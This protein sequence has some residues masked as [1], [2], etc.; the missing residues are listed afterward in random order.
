MG[1]RR[2]QVKNK[3]DKRPIGAIAVKR[4]ETIR[5]AGNQQRRRPTRRTQA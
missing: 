1:I 2:S 4:E 5:R 3:K